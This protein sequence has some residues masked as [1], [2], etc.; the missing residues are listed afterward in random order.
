MNPVLDPQTEIQRALHTEFGKL[1][2]RNSAYSQRAFSRKLG[3]GAAALSEIMKG[4]RRV[5]L[6]LARNLYA[7]LGLGPERWAELVSLFQRELVGAGDAVVPE[8]R[9]L[10]VDQ[11][12]VI[13]EWYHFAI[14]SL[15]ET[16]GFRSDSAWIAGRLGIPRR[17]AEQALERLERLEMLERAPD[18]ALK[19]TGVAYATT[20]GVRDASLARAHAED[21]E[22]ARRAL[23]R[24]SLEERD[25]TFITMA[26][27]PGRI[28][29]AKRRIRRFRDE[30]CAFLEGGKKRE[31]Y[32]FCQS[33]FPLSEQS[34]PKKKE[35]SP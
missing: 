29:E 7:K 30:L 9:Q 2:L 5:S 14:L 20:D 28:P 27:D 10:T 11:F 33:L 13:A 4:K 1:K 35:K 17:E 25:F 18:G 22:L 31:V 26:I 12:R 34:T 8:Y 6:K 3:I 19:C 15:A 24:D 32:K 21:L 23:E 16:E